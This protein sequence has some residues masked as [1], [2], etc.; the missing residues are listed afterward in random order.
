MSYGVIYKF[1]NLLNNKVYIGQ[2]KQDNLDRVKQHLLHNHHSKLF[3]GIVNDGLRNFSYDIIDSAETPEELNARELYWINYYDSIKTGYNTQ[4]SNSHK[5]SIKLDKN[6]LSLISYSVNREIYKKESIFLNID[7][8]KNIFNYVYSK[9]PKHILLFILAYNGFKL[10]DFIKIKVKDVYENNEVKNTVNINGKSIPL[11]FETQIFLRNYIIQN[12]LG[13]ESYIFKSQKTGK[14]FNRNYVSNLFSKIYQELK[15]ENCSEH[16]GKYNCSTH[17]GKYNY[18]IYRD[19][20]KLND[21][22]NAIFSFNKKAI[23]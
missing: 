5:I 7:T 6:K 13:M 3:E 23:I 17:I 18:T 22:V 14:P 4:H 9:Y 19:N 20:N 12:E 8:I 11:F 10:K 2:T 1:Q 15:I 16:M 21:Y